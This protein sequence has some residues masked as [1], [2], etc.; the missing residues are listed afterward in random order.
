MPI[1]FRENLYPP[2]PEQE[3]EEDPTQPDDT[4]HDSKKPDSPTKD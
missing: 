3:Q 2:P 4:P 1:P